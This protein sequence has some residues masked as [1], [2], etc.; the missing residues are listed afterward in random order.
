MRALLPPLVLLG[1][2]LP[3]LADELQADGRPLSRE[4][5]VARAR[6]ARL[7]YV[8]EQHGAPAHHLLQRDLLVALAEAGPVALGCE[9]FPRSLQPVL[10]RFHRGELRLAELP[11]ALDWERTWGHPWAAC[12]PLFRACAERRIPIVALNAERDLVA[13]V[14]KVGLAELPLDE[15]L[16]LPRIDLQ[17]PAHRERVRRTLQEAHPLPDAALERYYQAFTVWDEVMAASVCEAFLRDQRPGLRMLVVAG[18]AHIQTGTGIPDR[19]AR[20]LPAPRLIVACGQ[21]EPADGDVLLLPGPPPPRS[22]WF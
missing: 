9:Y 1:L 13:R 6:A 3:A 7:V 14:R 10:D 20:Q 11:A 18:I 5:L 8:G 16:G 19:V 17:V 15:L 22:R 2:C 12:E 4:E 21:V